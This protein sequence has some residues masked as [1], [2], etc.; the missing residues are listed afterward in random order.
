M[1]RTYI[2]RRQATVAEWVA[3]GILFGVCVRET[4]YK[5]IGRIWYAW[6]CQEATEKKLQSTLAGILWEAKRR[7]KCGENVTKYKPEERERAGW[8]VVMLGQRLETPKWEN[9]LVW[10]TELLGGD[11]RRSG[12]KMN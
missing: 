12:E 1:A 8:E 3:L 5:R 7:S 10:H 11:W 9:E 2:G 4:W 6:R